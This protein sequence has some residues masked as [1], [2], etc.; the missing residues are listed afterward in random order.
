MARR[1]ISIVS[2]FDAAAAEV[3]RAAVRIRQYALRGT[4]VRLPI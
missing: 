4:A 2:S 3:V 1:I